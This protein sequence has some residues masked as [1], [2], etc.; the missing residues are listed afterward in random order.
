MDIATLETSSLGDRT[1][2]VHDG[3][4]AV[5]VDPQR[6]VDRILAEAERAGVT[7]THV[8]ETHVHNDYVSGGLVLARMTGSDYVHAADEPLRFDHRAVADGDRFEVGSMAVEVLHTPGRTPHHLTYVVTAEGEPPAAFTCGSLLYGTVG[9]TD[10]ISAEQTD[11]LT[12]AQHR[13]AQRLASVLP[14][15]K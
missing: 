6:D 15:G 12:R 8:V 10:L 4:V 5:V 1:Y 13:S 14:R 9:R 3:S 2:L 7:I 11:E